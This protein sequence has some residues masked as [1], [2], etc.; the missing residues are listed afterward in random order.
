MRG[1]L[2]VFILFIIAGGGIH[3]SAQKVAIK[4]NLL[5]DLTL[6]P[7]VGVEVEL[8]K[9][10]TL[11]LSGGYN[12]FEFSE[13]KRFKHLLIQ[14]EY[15][16]WLCE[17]FNGTFLGLHLHAGEFSIA[18]LKLPF[19]FLSQLKGHLYEGYF[20]GGGVSIGHQLI[21]NKRWSME[22]SLGIG[23]ARISYDKYPCATCGTKIK[24]ADCNYFGPTKMALSLIYF[25]N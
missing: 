22:A 20:Y 13:G 25:F 21:L 18:N 23:Y 1:T 19:D 11:N 15:R 4:N 3:I 10:T 5:Y 14:P 17:A 2:I 7:N 8:S 24:S 16:Y 6:T 12:L 9:K